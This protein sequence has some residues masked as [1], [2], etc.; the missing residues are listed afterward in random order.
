MRARR[1]SSSL[2]LLSS[3]NKRRKR[4]ALQSFN[5]SLFQLKTYDDDNLAGEGGREDA[6]AELP[7]FSGGDVIGKVIAYCIEEFFVHLFVST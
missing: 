3:D 5:G 4:S 7:H 6:V 2:L 1:S